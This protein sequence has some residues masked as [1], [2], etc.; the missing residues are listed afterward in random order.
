MK[1]FSVS[2]SGNPPRP[3]QPVELFEGQYGTSGPI[4]SYDIAA[5]GRLLLIK[6]DPRAEEAAMLAFFPEEFHV[7]TNWF[8]E[9]KRLVPT[10]E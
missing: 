5:D 6:R 1:I 10:D 7:R 2:F 8:E 4:R 9:L 3:G